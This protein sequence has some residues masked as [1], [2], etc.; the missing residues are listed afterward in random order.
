MPVQHRLFFFLILLCISLGSRSE[1]IRD[2]YSE[3]GLNPFKETLNQSFNES[4]DPFSGGLQLSYTDIYLPGNGGMDVRI[5]RFYNSLQT[6]A[7]PSWNFYGLGWTMHFGRIV[8][9]WRNR[10]HLCNQGSLYSGSTIENPSLEHPDGSR[11][12]LVLSSELKD[13]TLV[14]RSN[15]KAECVDGME[16]M[17]V[18]APNGTKYYMEEYS[19]FQDEPSWFTT[20]IEDVHGNWIDIKYESNSL[21]IVYISEIY[22]SEEGDSS[23]I[24]TYEYDNVQSDAPTLK[25][26]VAKG[27]RWEYVFEDI[28]NYYASRHLKQVVRPDGRVWAYDY[29][30]KQ[31]DPNPDDEIDE[32]GLGSYSL[33]QVTYPD[34]GEIHYTYQYVQ[35]YVDS[36]HR[37]TSISSK[38]VV[39]EGTEE[40]VWTYEFKPSS[41][42]YGSVVG[43]QRPLKLDETVVTAPDAKYVYRHYGQDTVFYD[44]SVWHWDPASFGLQVEALVYSLDNVLLEKRK[45]SWGYRKISEEN[46]VH[47]VNHNWDATF[48]T[49][50][51]YVEA[52]YSSRDDKAVGSEGYAHATLYIDQDRFGNP[53]TIIET[54]NLLNDFD[55]VSRA[56]Y[57]HDTDTWILNKAVQ[58]TVSQ[59]NAIEAAEPENWSIQDET[60]VSQVDRVFDGIGQLRE[61]N[62]N[63]VVSKFE[64]HASG[65]LKST[66]DARHFLTQYS[67][68]QRGISKLEVHPESIEIRRD[69]DDIGRLKSETNG[70]GFTTNYGYDELNRLK[71]ISYPINSSVAVSYSSAGNKTR[72]LTRGNYSQ[73]DSYDGFGRLKSTTRTDTLSSNS[74]VTTYEYDALGRKTF[75][76]Y[77]NSSDGTHYVYDALGRIVKQQNADGTAVK[78]D[79]YDGKVV[80]TDER[81]NQT[82]TIFRVLGGGMDQVLMSINQPESVSTGLKRNILG[83]ITKV[84]QGENIGTHVV[85]PNRTYT[86]DEHLFLIEQTHPETGTTYY[87]H[88]ELGNNTS[89]R[90][91]DHEATRLT[92]D[93]LNRVTYIDYPGYTADIE[94]HYN[95]NGNI[96]RMTSGHTDWEYVYDD[97]DNLI[98]ETLTVTG[99]LTKAFNLHYDFDNL[100]SLEKI[101]YP[102]S[103]SVDYAPDAFG[104]PT[105]VGGF[106]SNLSFHPSGQIQSYTLSNGVTGS[107]TLNQRL[108]PQTISAGNLVGLSYTYDDAGNITSIENSVDPGQSISM[109]RN[110]SYDGVNRLRNARGS[111]G[112]IYFEYDH[113]G[114]ISSTRD[115][116]NAPQK[117]LYIYDKNNRLISDRLQ[118][119]DGSALQQNYTLKYDSLANI[120]D[121]I[122]NKNTYPLADYDK[123]HFDFDDASR[124]VRVVTDSTVKDY[125]YDGNGQLAVDQIHGT[126][127]LKYNIYTKSGHLLYEQSIDDCQTTNYILLGSSLIAKSD[128]VADEPLLDADNDGIRDCVE[129]QVGLSPEDPQDGNADSDNDGILNKEEL[130]LGTAIFGSGDTDGDGFSDQEEIDAG[131]DP[132]SI[133]SDRDGILDADELADPRLNPMLVDSDHDGVTDKWEIVLQT[134]PSN[135]DDALLDWDNDG[136]TNRQESLSGTD[137]TDNASMPEPGTIAWTSEIGLFDLGR[138]TIGPDGTIFVSDDRLYALYPDGTEKWEFE[139]N[140]TS[141]TESD[142]VVS[143]EGIIYV[144]DYDGYIYALDSNGSLINGWPYKAGSKI[145]SLSLASDGTV[146]SASRDGFLYANTPTGD[147]LWKKQIGELY[148]YFTAPIVGADGQLYISKKPYNSNFSVVMA[149][150]KDGS[151]DWAYNTDSVASGL[152]VDYDGTLYFIS[153]N[154]LFAISSQGQ[155]KWV[156]DALAGV[157]SI[158]SSTLLK[159][160]P[161]IGSDYVLA[162]YEDTTD[163]SGFAVINKE[164]GELIDKLSM[165]DTYVNTPAI[166]NDSVVYGS[167]K[168]GALRSFDLSMDPSLNTKFDYY[169]EFT[170]GSA[171]VIDKDGTVFFSN[172]AGR[173]FAIVDNKKAAETPWPQSNHDRFNSNNVCR[174]EGGYYTNNSDRDGDKIPDCE[175][176]AHGLDP[177]NNDSDIDL[178]E[179]TLTNYQEYLLGTD[180]FSR[181]SDMDG[182]DDNIELNGSTSPTNWDTD[183]DGLSDKEELDRGY[184]PNNAA[185]AFLDDDG[186]G[187]SNVQEGLTR[188]EPFNVNVMPEEGSQMWLVSL[189]GN[190]TGPAYG[191]DGT[192]YVGSDNNRVYALSPSG[193][194]KWEVELEGAIKSSP[195]ITEG[196]AIIVYDGY[197]LYSYAPDSSLNW[198]RDMGNSQYTSA[199]L[200]IGS[201]DSIYML[202]NGKLFVFNSDNGSDAPIREVDFGNDA[203]I[204][205][206]IA[207][208]G[209][210]FQAYGNIVRT[211][212]PTD[213]FV[214]FRPGSGDITGMAVTY[215][216]TIVVTTEDGYLYGLNPIGKNVTW[217]VYVG[218]AVYGP[219]IDSEGHIYI[220]SDSGRVYKY[221]V[222][223]NAVGNIIR[224]PYRGASSLSLSK[225][226]TIYI[227]IDDHLVAL[228]KDLQTLWTQSVI[229]SYSPLLSTQ[230]GTIIVS[231]KLGQVSAYAA[232]SKGMADEGWQTSG[233]D[234]FRSAFECRHRAGSYSTGSDSDL[235]G[236]PDCLDFR[237]SLLADL[238][239]EGDEDGDGLSNAV[240]YQQGTMLYITDTDNDGLSDKQEADLATNPLD[241]DTDGDTLGDGFEVDNG[242]DPK[243]NEELW[244]DVDGDGFS[245]RQEIVAHTDNFDLDS[246]PTRAG[247]VLLNQIDF[248]RFAVGGDGTFYTSFKRWSSST[249]SIAAWDLFNNEKWSVPFDDVAEEIAV[250]PGLNGGLVVIGQTVNGK[251]HV[252]VLDPNTGET[253]RQWENPIYPFTLVGIGSNGTVYLKDSHNIV[254]LDSKQEE[255]IWTYSEPD[256]VIGVS[257]AIDEYGYL[258]FTAGGKFNKVSPDGLHVTTLYDTGQANLTGYI[259]LGSDNREYV[260][261]DALYC[262]DRTTGQL[263]WTKENQADINYVSYPLVDS[264]GNVF[265]KAT[266]DDEVTTYLFGFS[267]DGEALTPGPIWSTSSGFGDVSL[268]EDGT[269][270]LKKYGSSGSH[271][272]YALTADGV[273]LW[274]K[275]ISGLTQYIL[276]NDGMIYYSNDSNF[277]GDHIYY[278]QDGSDGLAKTGWPLKGGNASHTYSLPFSGNYSPIVSIN[279]PESDSMLPRG[280]TIVL[281]GS[282]VD[283]EDGDLATSIEWR[284]DI[285]GLLGSGT[286]ITTALSDGVHRIT[287]SVSDSEGIVGQSVITLI[288]ND[289]PSITIASPTEGEWLMSGSL[290][291]SA[292]VS[293]PEGDNLAEQVKWYSDIDG[294]LGQGSSPKVYLTAYDQVDPTT[295][296]LTAKVTDSLGGE[297]ER[298]ISVQVYSSDSYKDDDGDGIPTFREIQ[299]GLNPKDP[300]DRLLDADNDGVN[301]YLEFLVGNYGSSEIST[302]YGYTVLHPL[303]TSGDMVLIGGDDDVYIGGNI[304]LGPLGQ[305]E[306]ISIDSANIIQGMGLSSSDGGFSISSTMPWTDAPVALVQRGTQFIYPQ[307]RGAHT[308]YLYGAG[309]DSGVDVTVTIAGFE[310]Q[311]LH[312]P[313]DTVVEFNLEDQLR[314]VE[315]SADEPFYLLHA[316]KDENGKPQDVTSLTPAGFELWG[317]HENTVLSVLEEDTQV[318]LYTSGGQSDSILLQPGQIYEPTLQVAD[319]EA[320]HIISDK[321]VSALRQSKPVDVT[322]SLLDGAPGMNIDPTTGTI[323]WAPS[324]SDVN[325]YTVEVEATDGVKTATQ[326]YTLEVV[327]ASSSPITPDPIVVDNG[328]ATTSSVGSWST[329]TYTAG[330]YGSN[331]QFMSGPSGSGTSYT[332]GL[333]VTLPGNYKVYARWTSTNARASDATYSVATTSGAETAVVSQK[334]DGGSW[335]LLG[336]YSLDANAAVTLSGYGNNYVIADAIR[337]EWDSPSQGNSVPLGI[338]SKALTNAVV[339]EDYRYTLSA[340]DL[341]G[342]SISYSK[343]DGPS[344]MT[345]DPNTGE[346]I[347]TPAAGDEGDHSVV[348]QATDGSNN[349]TQAFMLKVLASGGDFW[350]ISSPA[351][352]SVVAGES[353]EYTP[354]L[355]GP[356]S[357][358]FDTVQ[359]LDSVFRARYFQFA[360][361][362]QRIEVVCPESSTD[363]TLYDGARAPQVKQCNGDGQFPGTVS[364]REPVPG[365][366]IGVGA[367]IS[368]SKNVYV[369]YRTLNGEVR[370]NFGYYYDYTAAP[371]ENP[372]ITLL[373][374]GSNVVI[375][376]GSSIVLSGTANDAADGDLSSAIQW[377]SSLSGPIGADD[378]LSVSLSQ[379]IHLITASVTDSDGNTATASVTVTVNDPPT[380]SIASPS[381]GALIQEGESV[382]LTAVVSDT[383]GEELSDAISWT[384]SIQGALPSGNDLL[385]NLLPGAHEL[386]AEVSDSYGSQTSDKVNVTVNA[387]PQIVIDAPTDGA[388][389]T[390]GQSITLATTASDQEDGGLSDLVSWSSS[391]DGNLGS[392]ASLPVTLSAG[393]HV[394]TASVTDSQGGH[395]EGSVTVVVNAISANLDSDFD[396]MPDAWETAHGLNPEFAGDRTGDPDNDLVNNYLEYIGGSDPKLTSSTPLFTFHVVDP[397]Q[398]GLPLN[399]YSGADGNDIQAGSSAM[400]LNL[401]EMAVIAGSGVS[402]GLKIQGNGYFSLGNAQNWTEAPLPEAYRGTT[403]LYPQSRGS[404]IYYILAQENAANVTLTYD[405]G[406]Q[407]ITVAADT[408]SPIDLAQSSGTVKFSSDN[409]VFILHGGY[410]SGSEPQDVT[411]LTPVAFELW[412]IHDSTV[413]SSL[414]DDTQVN[415]YTSDG[416]SVP[417]TLQAGQLYDALVATHQG[418]AL[419]LVSDKPIAAVRLAE[420]AALTYKL[421]D[422]PLGMAIDPDTGLIQWAP[423]ESDVNQYTVTVEVS[424]G[425]TTT[426]QSF[427]LEVVSSVVASSSG[428]DTYIVDNGDALTSVVGSWLTSSYASGFYGDDYVYIQ[429]TSGAGTSYTWGLGVTQSG[430]YNVYARWTSTNA[431]ATDATYSIVTTGGTETKVVSQKTGGGS[432]NLLGTYSLDS[433][434]SVTLSGE[435]NNYIIADAIQ[436]EWASTG[437]ANVPPVITSHAPT[438]AVVDQPYSYT[439]SATDADGDVIS[440]ALSNGPVAMSVDPNSGVVN[441]TPTSGDQTTYVTLQATAGADTVEQSFKLQLVESASEDMAITSAAQ[442]SVVAGSSYDYQPLVSVPGAA[443]DDAT[444]F[445]DSVFLAY[446]FSLPEDSRRIEIVCPNAGTEVTLYDGVLNPRTVACNASG[447]AP[448]KAVLQ[449]LIPGEGISAGATLISTQ[450]VYLNYI[451]QSSGEIRNL[452]GH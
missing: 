336:T 31:D 378:S 229:G 84:F 254:A 280:S 209:K 94:N 134:D 109:A 284:S 442:T 448:G 110:D 436:V 36:D 87:E 90:V 5:N 85:G 308:Y 136:F 451:T 112:D 255:P 359:F 248:Y 70:R 410:S 235:D 215:Q 188:S 91:G 203:D 298:S 263:L 92:Y 430:T 337:I 366:G 236:I 44:L 414:E 66:E 363:V 395:A 439:I 217:Y 416:S 257:T 437:P 300:L 396:G 173:V 135:P 164:S 221:D 210:V 220:A 192:I 95:K 131:S 333:P 237:R 100:D 365:Q 208:D 364:F 444:M 269:I 233:H 393:T 174:F 286:N 79:Y 413:I 46:Y 76:S 432:W 391:I 218:D 417:V 392:S 231:D 246:Y 82:E 368:S 155:S 52:E 328:D 127:K 50:A 306:I 16:G 397:A 267:K 247:N 434:A 165:F 57:E 48:E 329:S 350:A 207:A 345:V 390:E 28:P 428:P 190:I 118:K 352:T 152:S 214:W 252:Y 273:V 260:L 244:V 354:I 171:P 330:Y 315:F 7:Y 446:N 259:A 443:V 97:N 313:L 266:S 19:F 119:S 402:Q 303:Q 447:N 369:N 234:S 450:P 319:G 375:E 158:P 317:I 216:G 332:W 409:P 426:Q 290:Y 194:K 60:I 177:N 441:W 17:L 201:G 130:A 168:G 228:D 88:D 276:G 278:F 307:T 3:P 25:A 380:L 72:T 186:D 99:L 288:M 422:A 377:S 128:D 292:S 21:G 386:T 191:L 421:I 26:I 367:I 281:S 42:S 256:S 411:A 58:E 212:L 59:A 341:D 408:V 262:I 219:V 142:P 362:V 385:V 102:D 175:E 291:P 22:R 45:K 242:Y 83:Q 160:N 327:S 8:T 318:D 296:V 139:F 96:E 324:E 166:A 206:A 200:G 11:E 121:K 189:D 258:Y 440:Y 43:G 113:I 150:S 104:R 419:H 146:Y 225:N 351:T 39:N 172:Y 264:N 232:V 123:K 157:P 163:S 41:Y 197:Y 361:A 425:D 183:F 153:E 297:S 14:T 423:T 111:W 275:S 56:T 224:L 30:E 61:E 241:A 180:Y 122:V 55:R 115:A 4:I 162:P 268:A 265:V 420:P 340:L 226:D 223:G 227:V 304:G 357:T 151:H 299:Y 71:S 449:A 310:I 154:R 379:G 373:N 114:N 253:I 32:D 205:I 93:G 147:L 108:F 67:D 179:D 342:D 105:K 271:S 140:S 106:A 89:I 283:E 295:H 77:P 287:A 33:K 86:Y 137:P 54:S 198:K 213:E 415:L 101:T 347:W 339:N 143:P 311:S 309:G 51:P 37:T 29:F 427:T 133:D 344:S 277:N 49:Y 141:G 65:D 187:Y 240:E 10:D 399:V 381:G 196:G 103:F 348:L 12:L 356:E 320:L 323:T 387:V 424:D 9:A 314:A 156:S 400:T 384:S 325:S 249:G 383:E 23:P 398:S 293:D 412:G 107:L 98:D 406:V 429:G 431:R 360:E 272:L 161:V 270:Y 34:G 405:G 117:T 35:F 138:V 349:A 63:G 193:K 374:P 132:T 126:Y 120:T 322:Y 18:T 64:Y 204:P 124:L 401:G 182:I 74:I 372:T 251:K 358:V 353:Y 239:G 338:T 261:S 274:T 78:F 250:S 243:S 53:Q 125:S 279:A 81:D 73:K 144:G 145:L 149:L 404:H 159:I 181:D 170:G 47:G 62:Q 116:E 331:Y 435:G 433:N 222:E 407:N 129:V 167:N 13:G 355:S 230:D 211:L 371:N 245:V 316:G 334:T 184:D 370:N 343:V 452:L 185:E 438:L 301:N 302:R 202:S 388:S 176:F 403:F 312:L 199:M 346:V 40:G 20:R 282:A 305:G 2:Y 394:I 294:Y 418:E 238:D 321:R 445:F 169:S 27:Q 15:W 80:Q 178:D 195:M 382:T 285:D 376:S 1:E 148:D 326:S 335:N 289:L 75:Q 69:V 389:F 24:V 6:N 38:T 68:Y